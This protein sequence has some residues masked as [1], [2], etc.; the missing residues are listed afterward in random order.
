MYCYYYCIIYFDNNDIL[1]FY[2]NA[3]DLATD[4]GHRCPII[5]PTLWTLRRP[6]SASRNVAEQLT[7]GSG[8]PKR[9]STA[10]TRARIY[11]Y[12]HRDSHVLIGWHILLLII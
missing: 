10:E 7:A 1:I 5:K 9:R 6:H 3:A 12:T 8:R 2:S 4:V 11:I